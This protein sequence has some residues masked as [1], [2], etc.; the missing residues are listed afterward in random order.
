MAQKGFIYKSRGSW[1]LKY[2]DDVIEEGRIVRK[3]QCKKLT[4]VCD[5]YRTEKDLHGLRDEIMGPINAGKRDAPYDLDLPRPVAVRATRDGSLR[6][7]PADLRVT[8]LSDQHTW[9]AVPPADPL[10]IGDWVA[11]GLSHPCTT[12]DKWPLIPVA[13]A[14]GT[15]TS[16]VHTFF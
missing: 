9:L 5:R 6:P 8:G 7:A 13:T 15:V 3:Q 11:L 10:D 12:F 14:D 2:R 1:F 16:Y 4:A